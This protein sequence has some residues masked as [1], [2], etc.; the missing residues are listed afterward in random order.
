MP[1]LLLA[2]FCLDQCRINFLFS[3]ASL[4]LVGD[5]SLMHE[6]GLLAA[7]KLH[8]NATFAQ[9]PAWKSVY[10]KKNNM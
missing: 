6:L 3:S 4:P 5:N 7:V 2:I 10:G 8:L 9:D 1:S